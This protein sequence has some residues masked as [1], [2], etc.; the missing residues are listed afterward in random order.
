VSVGDGEPAVVEERAQGRDQFGYL[1]PDHLASPPRYSNGKGALTGR[2]ASAD[3]RGCRP[4]HVAAGLNERHLR[5]LCP[6]RLPTSA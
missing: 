1:H 4:N 3:F 6:Q 2:A 5:P